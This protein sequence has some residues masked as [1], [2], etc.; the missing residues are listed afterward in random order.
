MYL[1]SFDSET[2]ATMDIVRKAASL[3]S[4]IGKYVSCQCFLISVVN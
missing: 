3:L 4:V 2:G 1:F